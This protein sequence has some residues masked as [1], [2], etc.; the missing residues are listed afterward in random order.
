MADDPDKRDPAEEPAEERSKL[1]LRRRLARLLER[2]E[3]TEEGRVVLTDV[4]GGMWEVSDRAKTEA[5]RLVA[6]EVRNYLDELKVKEDLMELVR[7]HSLEVK[8]SLH[9][10]PLPKEGGAGTAEPESSAKTPQGRDDRTA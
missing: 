8:L 10:K 5:V 2:R 1:G 4:L 3:I 9:L 6:R 7:S